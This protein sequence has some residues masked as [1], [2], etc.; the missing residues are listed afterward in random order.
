[1]LANPGKK[2]DDLCCGLAGAVDHT[3]LDTT[4]G[5]LWCTGA[6]ISLLGTLNYQ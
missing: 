6:V 3:G 4:A 2:T 5:V 1:M